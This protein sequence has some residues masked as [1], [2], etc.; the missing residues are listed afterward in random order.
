M[1]K[2]S[3]PLQQERLIRM[4]EA[5]G[6]QFAHKGFTDADLDTIAATA[7]VGKGTIYNYFRDK[8]DLYIHA[9][10]HA[11]EVSFETVYERIKDIEEPVEYV[12]VYIDAVLDFLDGSEVMRGLLNNASALL[13]PSIHHVLAKIRDE[14]IARHAV[15]ITDGMNKKLFGKV[16]PSILIHVME[17]SMIGM[18]YE[19]QLSGKYSTEELRVAFKQIFL[20]GLLPREN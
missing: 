12:N 8:Q 6:E 17:T 3:T 14:F 10:V 11:L 18:M 5:A 15:R 4:L 9:M 1:R 7:H 19:Q 20:Q 2:A 13:D 16:N